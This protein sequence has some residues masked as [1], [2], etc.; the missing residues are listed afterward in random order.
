MKLYK[1]TVFAVLLLPGVLKAQIYSLDQP[2]VRFFSHA[3]MEDIEAVN[4]S[5]QGLINVK[6]NSFT[7]RVPIKGF[8]F[9]KALMQEHFNENYMESDKYPY[10]TFKGTIRGN[11]D[12]TRDGVYEVEAAGKLNIHGIEQERTIP[13]KIVVEDGK[14]RLE[15]IFNVKLEDHDIEIPKIVFHNIA[16][17]IEVTVKSG[18]V[19][20]KK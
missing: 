4:H 5:T 10:G 14:P 13:A 18:L 3:P 8:K 2:F 9:A 19:L 6:D 20:Y 11:Y 15:T 7:F 12:I 1:L 16:E 17:V